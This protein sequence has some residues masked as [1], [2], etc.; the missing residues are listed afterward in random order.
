MK[1][2]E[3]GSESEVERVYAHLHLKQA[4]GRRNLSVEGASEHTMDR[5]ECEKIVNE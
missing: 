1:I 2:R 4:L 5:S 3:T